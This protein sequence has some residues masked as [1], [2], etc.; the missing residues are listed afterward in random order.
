M[1]CSL[2]SFYFL[3]LPLCKIMVS[4]KLGTMKLWRCLLFKWWS[5]WFLDHVVIYVCSDYLWYCAV[6]VIRVAI[7][8]RWI[9][10]IH[11]TQ[12]LEQTNYTTVN[13]NPT[14]ATVRRYLFTAKLLY[15]FRV[16]QHPSSGV[17]P[18]LEAAGTVFNTPDDGCC[19]T[20]NM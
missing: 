9:F 2:L 11:L 13:K 1:A 7:Q 14:D 20:R 12:M 10:F 15:M 3:M 5:S 6:L 17:W 18:V 4:M 19:D 16:S 8:F